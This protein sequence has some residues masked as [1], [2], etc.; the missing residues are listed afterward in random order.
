[1]Q[2]SGFGVAGTVGGATGLE[3]C[4]FG[5]GFTGGGVPVFVTESFHMVE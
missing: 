5:D 2:S 4:C 1:M 3:L